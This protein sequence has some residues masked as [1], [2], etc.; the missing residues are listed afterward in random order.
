PPPPPPPPP[1]PARGGPLGA[2][3]AVQATAAGLSIA[4]SGLVRDVGGAVAQSGVLGEGMNEPAI[5]YLIVYHIEIALLFAALLA[6]G[7]LVREDARTEDRDRIAN[8]LAGRTA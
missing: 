8:G 2:W 7:P 5:G 1:P 4:A 6:L 3:G